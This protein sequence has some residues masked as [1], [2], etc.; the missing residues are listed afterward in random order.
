MNVTIKGNIATISCIGGMS[1][2]FIK[3]QELGLDT[4]TVASQSGS[5][6]NLSFPMQRVHHGI[7]AGLIHRYNAEQNEKKKLDTKGGEPNN[8]PPDG[9]PPQGGTP[10]AAKSVEFKETIAIAA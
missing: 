4:F 2:V 10:G 5:M 7:F 8:T 1:G 3:V 6:Y 9:T